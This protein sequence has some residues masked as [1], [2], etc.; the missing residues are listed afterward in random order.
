MV[1]AHCKGTRFIDFL[2]EHGCEVVSNDYW[3][4]HNIIVMEKDTESFPIIIEKKLFYFNVNKICDS[5][6][7]DRPKFSHEL[8]NVS[9]EKKN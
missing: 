8:Y 9:V 4:Q 1:I 3:D 5:L 2:K 6:G 7:I